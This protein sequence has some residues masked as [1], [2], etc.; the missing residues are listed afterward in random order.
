VTE[1]PKRFRHALTHVRP[2]ILRGLD[3]LRE[4]GLPLGL[5]SNAG[6]DE[7]VAWPESP[8]ASAIAVPLFSCHERL[9]KPDPAIYRRAAERLG[10]PPGECLFVGDGGSHEHD[11]A[12]SAGMR[13]ALFLA[14]LTESAPEIAAARPRNTDYVVASMDELIALVEGWVA[15]AATVTSGL[16]GA[17][18]S[19]GVGMST[20]DVASKGPAWVETLP[21]AVTVTD[22]E[23]TI[24]A[25]NELA[26]EVF[27]E[28]GGA[29]LI[30]RSVF[31]CHPEPARTKTVELY[32]QREPNHYTITTR[33]GKR[34]I[35]HQM[36]WRR[37]GEFAGFVEISI[38]IPEELPHFD[39]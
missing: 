17:R 21:A 31:D 27:A 4:L 5:V 34:K 16:S 25:M 39:R 24:L 29:A 22:A 23:G 36:P 2:E 11:G 28:D 9:M 26:C 7:I 18:P 20:S 38:V 32:R 6:L 19:Q 15:P 30:G 12:R 13:T 33:Q 3:R 10:V 1:R 14:L 37:G 35:I 8:L